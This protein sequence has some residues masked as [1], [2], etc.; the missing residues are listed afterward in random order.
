MQ[1]EIK[2]IFTSVQGEGPYVG[3]KQLFVRFCTCNLQCAYC[4]TNFENG[5]KYSAEELE[6]ICRQNSDCHSVALTGGEPLLN[7]DFL[8]E[9]LPICPLP[10]YLE[11]NATNIPELESI[12]DYVDFISA[13]IK[14]PSCAAVEPM[15]EV[16]DKFFNTG[17]NKILFAKVVFD[18]NITE[19]EIIKTAKLVKKYNIE[20][21]LQPRMNGNEFCCTSEF[22]MNILDKFL[23]LYSN[24]RLIPQMHKFL[25]IN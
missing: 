4:D 16:H 19:Y 7:I 6:D 21:I 5:K 13:D 25:N 9:F 22:M 14:L 8:K 10:V 3:Y 23:K 17:K 1:T 12:I 24:V 2:E 20:L 18:S 15:W 11:T